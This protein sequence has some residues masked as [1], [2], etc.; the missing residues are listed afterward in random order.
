MRH[1]QNKKKMKASGRA[2]KFVRAI[3][4]HWWKVVGFFYTNLSHTIPFVYYDY[5]LNSFDSSI[6]N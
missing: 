6:F 2:T 1:V 3:G 5:K 4:L